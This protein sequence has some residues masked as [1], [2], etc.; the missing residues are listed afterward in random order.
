MSRRKVK[1]KLC[2]ECRCWFEP[3]ATAETRQKVCGEGCRRGRRRKQ[4]R[5]RRSKELTRYREEERERQR[6]SRARRRCGGGGRQ[7]PLAS[8]A[9]GCH[10]LASGGDRAPCH[11]LASGF[12]TVESNG[13]SADSW[14]K[15]EPVSRTTL[16]RQVGE[17]LAEIL[18]WM[19]QAGACEGCCHALG[20]FFNRAIFLGFSAESWNTMSR[21]MLAPERVGVVKPTRDVRR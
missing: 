6:A 4:A 1:R 13:K 15:P 10:A 3:S 2:T 19:E 8:G 20:R 5:R 12:N 18:A 7:A 21:S 11:G 9:S 17:T 16:G 14:N